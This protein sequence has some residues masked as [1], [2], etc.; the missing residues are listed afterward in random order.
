MFLLST[1]NVISRMRRFNYY[2]K[3]WRRR[4]N[5]PVN[6]W[7]YSIPKYDQQ[8]IDNEYQFYAGYGGR[9]YNPYVSEYELN[10]R[11]ENEQVVNE[12]TPVDV[13]KKPTVQAPPK[14]K[15]YMLSGKEVVDE[16][17]G[18]RTKRMAVKMSPS[19]I[20]KKI[21]SSA[22]GMVRKED[23]ALIQDIRREQRRQELITDARMN[24]MDKYQK[25]RFSEQNNMIERYRNE[26]MNAIKDVPTMEEVAKYQ[27]QYN[28]AQ[29]RL[30]AFEHDLAIQKNAV[31]DVVSRDKALS[32]SY[33][34]TM[35]MIS[36]AAHNV[37]EM[38]RRIDQ[39]SKQVDEK[40]KQLEQS[41]ILGAQRIRNE[42]AQLE[43]RMKDEQQ[44]MMQLERSVRHHAIEDVKSDLERVRGGFTGEVQRVVD[45]EIKKLALQDQIDQRLRSHDSLYMSRL[46]DLKKNDQRGYRQLKNE[47]S[48]INQKMLGY[49]QVLTR[50]DKV[51]AQGGLLRS[52]AGRINGL[53]ELLDANMNQRVNDTSAYNKRIEQVSNAIVHLNNAVSTLSR[54][55]S[56]AVINDI[57]K[58][59][60]VV[61]QT[62]ASDFPAL[63]QKVDALYTLTDQTIADVKNRIG[64]QRNAIEYNQ[65]GMKQRVNELF[66]RLS[67]VESKIDSITKNRDGLSSVVTE[68]ANS[69]KKMKEEIRQ[70]KSELSKNAEF[71]K[72]QDVQ[73]LTERVNLLNGMMTDASSKTEVFQRQIGYV[74]DGMIELKRDIESGKKQFMVEIDR[75][76]S[77]MGSRPTFDQI[78]TTVNQLAGSNAVGFTS[79][80]RQLPVEKD[81]EVH[82][83]P[84]KVLH[85]GFV[86]GSREWKRE[87]ERNP[88][89]Y[90]Q[91]LYDNPD[92]ELGIPVMKGESR[93][94]YVNR[95]ID[96]IGMQLR[97]AKRDKYAD[98]LPS[99]QVA[100]ITDER[101]TYYISRDRGNRMRYSRY[102]S[103]QVDGTDLHPEQEENALEVID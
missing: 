70:L 48:Q 73:A 19:T 93:R 67:S 87:F 57:A 33:K 50:Y 53:Q 1:G 25:K 56:P 82:E 26:T 22:V 74:K 6:D 91:V 94:D 95:A 35:Q 60:N 69:L 89:P 90:R 65:Q 72:V 12:T 29:E 20:A 64:F 42:I 45:A 52:L 16:L 27:L 23:Y 77:E 101:G 49:S 7:G 79:N 98:V 2:K 86:I 66:G 10:K 9:P 14:T 81:A 59:W 36:D 32:D 54:E 84:K 75:V 61:V 44:Q 28:T 21:A 55:R 38:Q 88:Y 62:L 99:I 43:G 76:Y 100:E 68:N 13:P 83:R 102:K 78:V 3:R 46:D 96:R 85:A 103:K 47:I 37:V 17:G 58:T 24:R 4:W 41:T 39:Y 5:Q 18:K 92:I 63:A 97:H 71:V 30:N 80:G 40:R 31:S 51:L 8:P 15:V 34:R 11:K